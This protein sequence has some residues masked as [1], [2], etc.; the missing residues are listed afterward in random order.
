MPQRGVKRERTHKKSVRKARKIDPEAV[1]DEEDHDNDRA[2]PPSLTKNNKDFDSRKG[3]EDDTNTSLGAMEKEGKRATT[4]T[5]KEQSSS[6]QMLDGTTITSSTMNP[7]PAQFKAMDRVVARDRDGVMY[8]AVVRRALYGRGQA[9]SIQLG[10]CSHAE[11]ESML[12]QQGGEDEPPCWHYFIHYNQ[13]RSN[14]DRWV[15]EYDVYPVNDTSK[16]YA[17]RVMEAHKQ[18]RQ[19]MTRKVKGKKSFQTIDGAKFLHEWRKRL[20]VI[21]AE[22]KIHNPRFGTVAP[23]VV[24][25]S[26][27]GKEPKE[28]KDDG[29]LSKSALIEERKFREKGLTQDISDANKINLPFGLKRALVE[30]WEII[31]QCDMLTDLPASVTV[32][33]A[34]DEYLKSKGVDPTLCQVSPGKS[35][36]KN[37][38]TPSESDDLALEAKQ[39]L[40][41]GG[42]EAT[43]NDSVPINEIA[44]SD[45][46]GKESKD[47][48]KVLSDDSK[49]VDSSEQTMSS[50]V[51][52]PS[53]GTANNDSVKEDGNDKELSE[54]VQGWVD[55]ANG[56]AQFFDEALPQRLL[57]REEYPQLR[58]IQRT[59]S[60]AEKAYSE[61]YGCE[62][63]LRMFT[64]LP[65]L[66]LKEFSIE[67][68][69]PIFAKLN[70]FARF[71]HKNQSS[72]LAAHHRKPNGD[73]RMEAMRME[74][75]LQKK[76]QREAQRPSQKPTEKKG[77]IGSSSEGDQDDNGIVQGEEQKKQNL[78]ES[79]MHSQVLAK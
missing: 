23:E 56:I 18:L 16:E 35:R 52:Q 59:E 71:L 40:G 11:A 22:F 49:K 12:Q 66:L 8:D 5:A 68:C 3:D 76:R 57:Y 10:F 51:E 61:I 62:Y 53:E 17:K 20:S 28:K 21:D 58:V 72:L 33:D 36:T 78:V 48:E 13:W 34:L 75:K 46:T 42:N 50:K 31:T 24:V 4:V 7:P 77:R 45:E 39:P 79:P 15:R 37:K 47:N 38:F 63:L 41:P 70:D 27:K 30:Q 44:S 26:K 32:R 69:R 29:T 74:A 43:S 67:E 73:E 19:D 9:E 25:P 14:W 65:G 1:P 55:M 6:S 2:S 54:E 64:R 60:L